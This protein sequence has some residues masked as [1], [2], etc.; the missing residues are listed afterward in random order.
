MKSISEHDV[1][2]TIGEIAEKLKISSIEVHDALAILEDQRII[3]RYRDSVE[4]F[5]FIEIRD[6]A[7]AWE[8]NPDRA[9]ENCY[10]S[11]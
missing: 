3:K 6:E 10:G 7:K 11:I 2:I 5:S 9:Y 1:E 8:I 4:R